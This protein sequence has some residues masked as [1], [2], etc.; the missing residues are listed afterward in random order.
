MLRVA[1]RSRKYGAAP[2]KIIG[3]IELTGEQSRTL[4]GDVTIDL[5]LAQF[6]KFVSRVARIGDGVWVKEPYLL[7]AAKK[8]LLY[9]DMV[10][11]GG[12]P[13]GPRMQPRRRAPMDGYRVS[14][15]PAQAMRRKDSRAVLEIMGFNGAVRFLV[16]MDKRVVF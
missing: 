11:F 16:H 8:D 12:S 13:V 2:V 4:R 6:R 10:I 5:P 3:H 9:D 1:A 15:H 14:T 7:F